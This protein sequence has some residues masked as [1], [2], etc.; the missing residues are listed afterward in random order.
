MDVIY[1]RCCGLDIHG[2]STAGAPPRER[3]PFPSSRPGPIPSRRRRPG[4]TWESPTGEIV[5]LDGIRV[6][7]ITVV[8]AG[9]HATQL[10]A[11]WGA[12]VIKV[13]KPGRGD[14]LRNWR[15]RGVPLWWKVYARNKKSLA[16]DLSKPEGQAV[17][18]RLA[19]QADVFITNLLAERF[20]GR[21][22][23]F[24]R[25]FRAFERA[26][27]RFLVRRHLERKAPL[28]GKIGERD[29]RCILRRRLRE[30]TG[31]IGIALQHHD[32]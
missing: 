15:T 19:A 29:R 28:H 2:R 25:D 3:L 22:T 21:E 14:D 30:K 12:E 17:L 16:L 32:R 4:C 8:W 9:P 11:E 13:E 24:L 18:H 27:L 6:A 10:L 20:S 5:P 7:D 31:G 1:P 23:P 26:P